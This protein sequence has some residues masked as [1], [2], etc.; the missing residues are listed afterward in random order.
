MS[1]CDYRSVGFI[2]E[3]L[4]YKFTFLF[5]CSNKT[6][7]KKNISTELVE[8]DEDRLQCISKL[9]FGPEL[10]NVF[11]KQEKQIIINKV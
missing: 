3:R 9:K 10:W 2:R 7:F 5:K 1:F 4:L 8:A 11:G 6:S